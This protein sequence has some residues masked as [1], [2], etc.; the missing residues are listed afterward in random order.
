MTPGT[1]V[2]VQQQ[3]AV[4]SH[5]GTAMRAGRVLQFEIPGLPAVRAAIMGNHLDTVVDD[6]ALRRRV[7]P[8]TKRLFAMKGGQTGRQQR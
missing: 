3:L 7:A 1:R 2:A 5:R 4:L 8:G 6:V